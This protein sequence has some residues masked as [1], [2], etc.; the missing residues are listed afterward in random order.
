[1]KDR[2]SVSIFRRSDDFVVVPENGGGGVYFAV[3][4]IARVALTLEELA[5]AIDRAIAVSDLTVR[6]KDLRGYK[7]PVLKA[8]GAKSNRKFDES[9]LGY[10]SVLRW[11]AEITITLY[12]R[13]RDG[14][15][16]EPTDRISK[17]PS[18]AAPRDIAEAAIQLMS[19]AA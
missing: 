3:E 8:V 1:M 9:V 15:G 18:N 2:F 14:R 7:S 10:C 16:F 12:L 6:N 13:A 4:P 5:P 17:L 11:D 19:T